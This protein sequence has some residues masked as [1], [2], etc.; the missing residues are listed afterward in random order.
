MEFVAI[1]AWLPKYKRKYV[2]GDV[3][4][5]IALAGLLIPEALGYA[6][7]AGLPPES[8][9][10]ATGIGL[11]AYPLFGSS[12]HLAVSPTSSSAAILAASVAVA[13]GDRGKY[14]ILAATVAILAGLAFL[15]ATFLRLGFVS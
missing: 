14:V 7:I 10:Y 15:L 4:A 8:G 12:R 9:L 3:I 11:L 5:G 6:G 13:A 2:R 1:S